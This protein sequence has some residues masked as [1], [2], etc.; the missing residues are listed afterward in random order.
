MEPTTSYA[1]HPCFGMT[2][3]RKVG[4][5]HLP[6]APRSNAKIRFA[7]NSK[8]KPAMMPEEAVAWMD[9]IVADGN[10]VDIVGITGPGDPL[11]VPEPTLRTLRLVRDKFPEISLCLTTLGVGGDLVADELAEIGLSHITMLVDAVTPEVAEKIYA[12]IRPSTKT[13]PLPEA[14]KYLL[15][16]QAKAVT[17]FKRAGITVKINTTVYPGYNAG[18]VEHVAAAMATLGADIMGVVPYLPAN[19]DGDHPA[20][21]GM[22]LISTVRDRAARHM[23]LMPAWDECGEDV[24]GLNTPGKDAAPVSVMP[25]PSL[26]RP[27]VAVVS[28]DGMDVDM[29]LGHAVKILIYGPREDGLQCLLETREAPEPGSG[30]SRWKKLATILH[31][32]FVLLTASAGD[33]PRQI[34]SRKGLSVLITDGEIVGTVDVLYGGGK[35]GKGRKSAA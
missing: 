2:S 1:N 20:E 16:E 24:V 4:R 28:S 22:E 33:T 19:E 26:A 17:A 3:R 21:S 25:K 7:D 11:A 32:C 18:H 23:D 27:N 5:L 6:V 31:D 35:K 14:A 9:Q 15:N 13:M 12:W 8:A 34:L 29:H 30:S 10:A